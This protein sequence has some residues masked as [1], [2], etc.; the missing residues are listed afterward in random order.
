MDA[1]DPLN[2]GMRIGGVAEGGDRDELTGA[3]QPAEHV[4]PETGV[5]PYARQ[6]RRMQHL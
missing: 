4:L 6:R 3:P 1:F 2:Q 5:I